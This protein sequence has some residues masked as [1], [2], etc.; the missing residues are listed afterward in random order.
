MSKERIFY[1]SEYDEYITVSEL[2]CQYKEL[3]ANRETEAETFKDYI[4]NCMYW[5][6]GTLEEI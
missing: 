3:Y 5:N 6:N 1:D 4:N 2:E